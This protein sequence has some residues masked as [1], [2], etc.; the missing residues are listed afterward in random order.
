MKTP[1]QYKP[2]AHQHSKLAGKLFLTILDIKNVLENLEKNGI[3]DAQSKEGW[4]LCIGT[5]T[6]YFDAIMSL[7]SKHKLKLEEQNYLDILK[8][9]ADEAVAQILEILLEILNKKD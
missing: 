7:E 5:L 1:L 4:L 3:N 8:I 2:S 9:S 6:G